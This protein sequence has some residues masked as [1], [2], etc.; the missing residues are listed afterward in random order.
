MYLEKSVEELKELVEE[1][2]YATGISWEIQH[3]MEEA[4]RIFN[5]LIEVQGVPEEEKLKKSMAVVVVRY[6]LS[7]LNRLKYMLPYDD[8][9]I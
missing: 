3:E 8:I 1:N 6:Y 2:G 9:C 7:Q 5:Y 4:K